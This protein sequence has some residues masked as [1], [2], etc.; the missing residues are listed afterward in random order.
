M[1]KK[2]EQKKYIVYVGTISE[3]SQKNLQEYISSKKKKWRL[4]V[5]QSESKNS[6]PGDN[7]ISINFNNENDIKRWVDE[8]GSKILCITARSEK[9][10]P[11]FAKI[12]PYLPKHIL[13]PSVDSLEKATEKTSMRKAFRKHNPKISPRFKIV[14]DLENIDIETIMEKQNC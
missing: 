8:Y 7:S 3:R 2:T 6:I 4:L 5:L 1:A 11:L 13:T 10:I 14:N 12:I 9:N